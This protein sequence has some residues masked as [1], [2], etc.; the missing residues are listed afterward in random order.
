MIGL[1]VSDNWRARVNEFLGTPLPA[2]VESCRDPMYGVR[3]LWL[4]GTFGSC[5]NDANE[6]TVTFHYRAWVL[7][8]PLNPMYR[9]DEHTWTARCSLICFYTV[10]IHLPHMVD[11][12][13]GLQQSWPHEEILTSTELHKYM[14]LPRFFDAMLCMWLTITIQTCLQFQS[15]TLKESDGLCSPPS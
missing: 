15:G 4:R 6:A 10:E 1:A 2:L 9:R 14:F 12:Q 8:M 11:R 7:A 3:L 5:P 13:F